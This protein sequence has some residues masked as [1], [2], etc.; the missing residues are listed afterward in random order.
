M[1]S[2]AVR[3]QAD[4]IITIEREL[5][6]THLGLLVRLRNLLTDTQRARLLELRKETP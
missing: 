3:W 1:Q 6:R 2:V 5:K 4:K